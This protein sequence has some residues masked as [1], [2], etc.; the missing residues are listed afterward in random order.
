MQS[1]PTGVY[2]Y[3]VSDKQLWNAIN[4]LRQVQSYIE[5]V[6]NGVLAKRN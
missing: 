5:G 6:L 2:M 4:Q 3:I 1:N